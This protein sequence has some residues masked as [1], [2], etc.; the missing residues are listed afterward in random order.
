MRPG[1]RR[2]DL[3]QFVA[4]AREQLVPDFGMPLHRAPLL[5]R[6]R[7][8]LLEERGG[9]RDLP[10]VVQRAHETQELGALVI[11]PERERDPP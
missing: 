5:G 4:R 10:D 7:P 6:Q 2:G 9:D 11:D 1:D 3:E 8:G